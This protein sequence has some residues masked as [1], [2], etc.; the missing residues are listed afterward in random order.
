MPLLDKVK[1]LFRRKSA[2]KTLAPVNDIKLGVIIGFVIAAISLSGIL[3]KYELVLLDEMF[4]ARGEKKTED[5]IAIVEI[6]DQSLEILGRWPWPR[7]HHANFLNVLE[8]AKPKATVFDILFTEADAEGDMPFA[9]VTKESGNVYLAAYFSLEKNPSALPSDI[10]VLRKIPS[11][12]YA[13]KKGDTFPHASSVTLPVTILANAAKRVVV[14]NVPQ[15]DDG[16]T[17]RVPL[18]IEFNGAL[19][20]ALSLQVACDYFGVDVKDVRILPRAVML[21]SEKGI[22]RIP[23]D[24]SGR[25][26]LDYNGPLTTF[27]RYS[28]VQIIQDYAKAMAGEESKILKHLGG[29]VL[30][31]GHTATGTVDA[32]I[33]PFSNAYPAVGVHATA[34]SNILDSNFIERASGALNT[35]VAIFLGILVG[36]LLKRG[37]RAAANFGISATVFILYGILS[38]LL[39]AFFNFWINTFA[40]LL[41][42]A[43]AYIG[44][45]VN[46]YS[47]IRH[48]KKILESELLI[49]RTIQQ[50]FFPKS[51]PAVPFLEFAAKCLPAKHIGGDLYD[52]VMLGDDRVGILI[53]DVSGKGV[54]AALY[55]ARTISEFR[56]MVHLK[57]DPA[58]TLKALNDEVS[59]E[60]MEKSFVTMQY[61]IMDLVS[62]K[63]LFSNGGHNTVL[64]FS[65]DTRKIDEV[66]TAGGMPIGVMEGIDFDNKEISMR[67]GD[68]L[69]L[70]TDG[71]SES[72]NTKRKEFGI[73]RVKDILMANYELKAEEVMLKVLEEIEKFSKGA[74]QHDDMTIIVIKAV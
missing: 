64:H 33:M 8:I 52:F 22:I 16:A 51:Y 15:D 72:M 73:P 41:V 43:A 6:E 1:S 39:F 57:A 40:P 2:G 54:P 20:P 18:V 45:T 3:E 44:A 38:F 66:D 48:E 29:K 58:S 37:R 14:T 65:K 9:M 68:I 46:Q 21:P 55:M 31:V 67:R 56:S 34:L 32:R 74:P 50:S 59:K 4:R 62:Q 60:G 53:G 25:M 47:A 28:Y 7:M 35:F 49:A 69:F 5:T 71:I 27:R 61:I 30:F 42:I 23:T 19:Y 10:T 26:I 13:V 24:E 36:V 70:Y 12:K 11:L 63:A 17:R